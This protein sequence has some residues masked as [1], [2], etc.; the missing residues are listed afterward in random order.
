MGN[1]T[2]IGFADEV[3]QENVSLEAA[4][5]YHLRCNHYPPPPVIMVKPCIEA[6]NHAK[7][8]EYGYEVELPEGV[9]WRGQA[10]VPVRAL[11]ESFHLDAFIGEQ[12]EE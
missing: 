10:A 6:I 5:Q 9:M 3:A 8:G 4:V 11:V 1:A 7:N 12:D 2:S